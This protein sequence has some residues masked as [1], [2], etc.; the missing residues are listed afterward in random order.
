LQKEIKKKHA[1]FRTGNFT[2][3]SQKKANKELQGRITPQ[4]PD[5]KA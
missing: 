5:M 4:D 2:L 1:F 3:K